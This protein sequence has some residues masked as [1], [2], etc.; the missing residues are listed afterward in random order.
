MAH[1]IEDAGAE[2]EVE[3]ADGGGVEVVQIEALVFDLAAE[4]LARK[5]KTL[6]PA[7]EAP[8]PR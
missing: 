7:R 1:V 3:G 2:H 8:R 6:E 5:Q 4:K